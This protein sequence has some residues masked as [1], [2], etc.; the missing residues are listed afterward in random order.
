M[1]AAARASSCSPSASRMLRLL[2]GPIGI[3]GSHFQKQR[4][5]GEKLRNREIM[6]KREESTLHL[7]SSKWGTRIRSC[8]LARIQLLSP[9]H[10]RVHQTRICAEHGDED[11]NIKGK[12]QNIR[13]A[14]LG[15]VRRS[16]A[17]RERPGCKRGYHR[18]HPR[19][20]GRRYCRCQS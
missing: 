7:T 10:N 1:L 5:P 11:A 20:R 16:L 14:H 2:Y 8:L 15:D 9:R 18:C 3:V 17:K 4:S 12:I 19:P 13:R 6:L